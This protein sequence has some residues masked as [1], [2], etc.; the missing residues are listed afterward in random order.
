MRT[1][2][3]NRWLVPRLKLFC[4]YDSDRKTVWFC[5]SLWYEPILEMK[6]EK[7]ERQEKFERRV[8]EML[9][10]KPKSWETW[11]RKVGN[12]QLRSESIGAK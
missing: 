10:F 9:G 1:K 12:P 5:D 6:K 4:H 3:P 2:R 8:K 7:Y 11:K